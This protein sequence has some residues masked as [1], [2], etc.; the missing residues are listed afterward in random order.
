MHQKVF[1]VMRTRMVKISEMGKPRKS[2]FM[3][4]L[5]SFPQEILL[6]LGH[7]QEAENGGSAK[8]VAASKG[9]RNIQNFL[10]T[11]KKNGVL[12]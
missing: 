10:W 6:L 4:D 9:R 5:S 8:A 11:K 7:W 2:E 12:A 3:I 1:E